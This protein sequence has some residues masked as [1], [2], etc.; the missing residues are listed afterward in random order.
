MGAGV[1]TG[2]ITLVDVPPD[3]TGPGPVG[4]VGGGFVSEHAPNKSA[5][6]DTTQ[7]V[8]FTVL[9]AAMLANRRASNKREVPF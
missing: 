4:I 5:H 3:A 1:G 8:P 2:V 7:T 9:M 6:N